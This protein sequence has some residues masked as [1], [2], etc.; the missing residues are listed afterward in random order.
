MS[1]DKNDITVTKTERE[2]EMDVYGVKCTKLIKYYINKTLLIGRYRTIHPEMN[3]E[4]VS[5]ITYL[6]DEI[7][8]GKR[9]MDEIDR[10][11]EIMEKYG[12]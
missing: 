12:R 4:N 9:A 7:K 6:W 11:G 1:K 8:K 10:L 5:D 2:K 3:L